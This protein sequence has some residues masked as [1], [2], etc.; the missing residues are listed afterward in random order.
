MPGN[1]TQP[2]TQSVPKIE[3]TYIH[4]HNEL[5]HLCSPQGQNSASTHTHTHT[6]SN[7]MTIND[8]VKEG[9]PTCM[10]MSTDLDM[11]EAA[12]PDVPE[13]GQQST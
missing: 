1:I 10:G 3:Q 9:N 5:P 13:N 7:H 8:A 4:M 6:Y 2:L 12:Q 11:G